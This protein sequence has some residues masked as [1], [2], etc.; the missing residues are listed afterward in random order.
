MK[1]VL[2][3]GCGDIGQRVALLWQQKDA[4]VYGLARSEQSADRLKSLYIQPIQGDLGQPESLQGIFKD[5]I[6]GAVVYYFAPPP[7]EGVSDIFMHNFLDAVEIGIK[8]AKIIQ[9]STTAVYGDCQGA[10]I[11]EEQAVNPQT[12]RGWRRLDAENTL[13]SWS[14]KTGVPV[15]TLRVGGIYGPGRLP[16]TRLK[17]G[18]PILKEGESPFTNRIHQDDLAQ[19]CLAAARFGKAGEVYNVSDGQPSTMS[20][21]FKAVAK[22]Q[23]LPLPP[24]VSREEAENVLTEGMLSYLK[25]SRR[26]DNKKMLKDFHILLHYANLED[27]L[28]Q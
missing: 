5:C 1:T 6:E 13:R 10:W 17:K 4:S 7:S 24:E 28:S 3:I 25:E 27:G 14:E 21:Y 9:I 18:L 8:P 2:I 26:L 12:D 15:V 11:T 19:V 16:I 20:Y 23:G 22:A